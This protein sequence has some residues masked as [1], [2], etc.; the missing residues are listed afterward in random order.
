MHCD[1]DLFAMSPLHVASFETI[2]FL[3]NRREN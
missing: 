1:L 3:D 2:I